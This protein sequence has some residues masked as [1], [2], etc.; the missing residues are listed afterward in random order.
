MLTFEACFMINVVGGVINYQQCSLDE[1]KNFLTKSGDKNTKIILGNPKGSLDLYSNKTLVDKICYIWNKIKCRI[2]E[3]FGCGKNYFNQTKINKEILGFLN[4][5]VAQHFFDDEIM[6]ELVSKLKSNLVKNEECDKLITNI[7]SQKLEPQ[8]KELEPHKKDLEQQNQKLETG[9][10][11][12]VLPIGDSTIDNIYWLLNS[13]GSNY[14][15]AEHNCVEGQ[16]HALLNEKEEHY[17]IKSCAF[18]GFTTKSVL[19]DDKVGRVLGISSSNELSDKQKVYL[20]N[21]KIKLESPSYQINPLEKLK[22][23]IDKRQ[24]SEHFVVVSVG[25]N[26]FRELLGT[27]SKIMSEIPAFQQRYLKILSQIKSLKGKVRPILMFQYRVD[28]GNHQYGVYQALGKI[29]AS[30]DSVA[31]SSLSTPHELGVSFIGPLL[32]KLYQP[33]LQQAQED[34]IPVLDLANTFDPMNSD[35]YISQIEPSA[36]GGALIAQGINHIIKNHD[37]E[38]K[39]SVIYAKN[40]SAAQYSGLENKCPGDWKVGNSNKASS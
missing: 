8:K 4:Y 28:A 23:I 25:G 2:K 7:I 22:K 26:D 14:E 35:L 32:E 27:P 5:G 3:F 30:I 10:K 37:F 39:K 40:Y 17:K 24:E 16:L 31:Q 33:I 38:S 11:A 34:G 15:E 20:K 19:E 1:Y 36:Q 18:D 13:D 9:K 12:Y 29:A 21:R 6:C